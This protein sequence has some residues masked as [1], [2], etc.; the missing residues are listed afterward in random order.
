MPTI[1]LAFLLAVSAA[2]A[3]AQIIRTPGSAGPGD[4]AVGN[5]L[6]EAHRAQSE[7]ELYRLNHLPGAR[8]SAPSNCDE[9]V[10]NWCYWYDERPGPPEPKEIV[11][12]RAKLITT[13]ATLA[14][15]L[16]DDRWIVA[17]RVRYLT[18]SDRYQEALAAAKECGTGGWWCDI[19]IGFSYHMLGDD[20]RSDSAYAVA[21]GRM[22]PRD[23]CQW[24]DFSMLLDDD[25]RQQYN[26]FPCG[27]PRRTAFE[28]RV[29]ALARTLYGRPGNDT[30][31]EWYARMTMTLMLQ[32]AASPHQNGFDDDER[33]LLLRFGWARAWARGSSRP[34]GPGDQRYS[35]DIISSEPVP[36]YRMIPAGFV[37]NDPSLSDSTNWR[38]HLP[39]VM[40]RYAPPYAKSLVILEHQKAVFKRGDSA[41]V[42]LSYDAGSAK[43]LQGA[44]LEA[45]LV[46]TPNSA[47]RDYIARIHDAPQRGVLTVKAPWGPLLMSAEV[48]APA[49]NAVARAR[50]GA[51]PPFAVGTRVTLS[52]LLFFKPYGTIPQ[53]AEEAAPHA[54][55]TE[56]LKATDKLGVYWEAYGTDPQGEPM[57][58]SLTVVKEV[59]EAG[60][61]R[62]QAK[63]LRLVREA[64]P[65]SVT[66]QDMSARGSTTSARALELDISTLTKG[67]YIVQLEVT[68]AG[69]YVVRADHRIEIAATP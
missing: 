60:F 14:H 52:D 59:E 11:D 51:N 62:R 22:M 2:T 45:A 37:L 32:D 55:P 35:F 7:F 4:A 43:E 28:D 12:A 36:A 50:Y 57:T 26:R 66:V 20:V 31:T 16:P 48:T 33:E 25:A 65:V 41:L 44:K 21:L 67:S 40:G 10:G 1:R 6:A 30:R 8:V 29:F 69:Q 24:R 17:Q 42:V 3:G 56:R 63:A 61:F 39:P 53:T 5:T 27:D 38:L 54:H 46:V 68:V 13:L 19:M 58:I 64:T 49:K 15:E 23:R 34:S 18:E 47:A 9:R